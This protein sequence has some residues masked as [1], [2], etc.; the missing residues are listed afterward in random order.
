VI[1][2]KERL[3]CVTSV[4]FCYTF[5]ISVAKTLQNMLISVSHSNIKW[6]RSFS[7]PASI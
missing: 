5:Q 1:G 3:I 7:R 6:H 4:N 2:W